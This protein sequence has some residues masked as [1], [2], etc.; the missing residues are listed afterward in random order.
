M[1][2]TMCY[3][4]LGKERETEQEMG[5]GNGEE[6]VSTTPLI[7]SGEGEK[8]VSRIPTS[9]VCRE[10]NRLAGEPENRLISFVIYV[11]KRDDDTLNSTVKY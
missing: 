2:V 3:N 11:R 6:C 5:S 1:N 10:I 4:L 7:D 8:R 9:K